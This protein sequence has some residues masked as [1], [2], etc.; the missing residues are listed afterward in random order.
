MSRLKHYRTNWRFLVMCVVLYP[1]YLPLALWAIS[2]EWV[3]DRLCV[4][5]RRW[6]RSL[7]TDRRRSR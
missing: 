6:V 4:P 5:M 3:G 1:V 7:H 2:G